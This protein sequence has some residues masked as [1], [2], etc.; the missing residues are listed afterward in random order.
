MGAK[1][2]SKTHLQNTYIFQFLVPFRARL[3]SKFAINAN[4]TQIFF[5]MKK[6]INFS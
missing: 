4:M 3:A 5:Y 2:N 1:L 6:G